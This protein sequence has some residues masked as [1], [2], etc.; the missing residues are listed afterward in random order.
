M[1][2]NLD[3]LTGVL[4]THLWQLTL[5]IPLAIVVVRWACRRRSHLGYVILL[6]VLVKCLVPPL[7]SSPAGVFSWVSHALGVG[8]QS[9]PTAPL[10][11]PVAT[12]TIAEQAPPANVPESV[13]LPEPVSVAPPE[14]SFAELLSEW[15]LMSEEQPS[16][17]A[18]L[19]A[20][21]TPE[22]PIDWGQV[23]L[24]ILLALWVCGSVGVVGYLLAKRIYLERF[25]DDT[26][27]DSKQEL[28]AIVSEC[29][30]VLDLRR[31]PDLVVTTHPTIPFV[32]GWWAPRLVIPKH[33]VDRSTPADMRLI[34]AHEL[35]HLRRWDTATNWIQ[36]A[37]QAVWWFH[38]LVWWLNAEIRR[39]RESCC[40]E[41]VVARLKCQPSQYAH[42]LLNVLDFQAS[43]R[44]T[45]GL[46]SLSPFEVTKQRLQNIMQPAG[47]F[48]RSTPLVVWLAFVVL[49]L[50]VLPGA[51][52]TLPEQKAVAHDEIPM[53]P[54]EVAVPIVPPAPPLATAIDPAPPQPPVPEWQYKFDVQRAYQYQV[55]IEEDGLQGTTRH[56]GQPSVRVTYVSGGQW[57]LSISNPHLMAT[58]ISGSSGRIPRPPRIPSPFERG[59]EVTIDS[60]GR[61]VDESGEGSLPLF[62]GNWSNW[63]FS[64]LPAANRLPTWEEQGTT[65]LSLMAEPT[66]G[67]FGTPDRSP[68]ARSVETARLPATTHTKTTQSV[69][70]GE[71]RLTRTRTVR[72][73]ELVDGKPRI[74]LRDDSIWTF[75]SR[76]QVPVSLTGSG[77][78]I[79]RQAKQSQTIPFKYT[80]RLI[81]PEDTHAA[82]E[83]DKAAASQVAVLPDRMQI[84]PRIV[85]STGT[86][87]SPDKKLEKG[88]QFLIE[89]NG[90]FFPGEILEVPSHESVKIHDSQWGE[91]WDAVV[92]RRRLREPVGKTTTE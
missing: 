63:L 4:W 69:A 76:L 29:A 66:I 73:N 48:P 13:T 41:E 8:E 91:E 56:T 87:V 12:T 60:Q 65:S 80:V 9:P 52:F 37:V 85:P 44:A 23:S 51:A 38:P 34:I 50:I 33:I 92:P 70:K 49:T 81:T 35:N 2:L 71:L 79:R 74:E 78:L 32:V 45:S 22:T 83:T 53:V 7:W 28:L 30:H 54:L 82:A 31:H 55:S 40:D 67:P 46:D 86:P 14:T 47:Q 39:W 58:E 84:P 26:R 64:S 15:G 68:F 61:L 75:D 42:C 10:N 3:G 89:W 24:A 21:P 19:N 62:L 16:P 1:T 43:L 11:L 90:S 25:H 5:L 77:E 18:P 17:S 57:A 20:A 6:V 27:V 59:Y 88:P 36:L 72:T